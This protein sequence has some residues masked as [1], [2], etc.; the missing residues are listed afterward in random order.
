M[1]KEEIFEF[2]KEN[3]V[4]SLATAEDNKPH[5]RIIMLYR[6]DENGI[7][8]NTGENKDVHRQL[9]ENPQVEMCFYNGDRGLQVRISGTVE[10]LEDL[11]LKKRVVAD[12]PFL[13]EWVD[14]EGFEVLIVYALK[15]ARAAAWTMETNFQPKE[16]IQL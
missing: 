15:N 2:I 5:V 8:F 13:K 7:I 10:T 16:Y 9:S 6:A 1:T 14:R 4:F 11:E 3:P 12:Y